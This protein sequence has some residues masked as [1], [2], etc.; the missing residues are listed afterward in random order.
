MT[1]TRAAD[2]R[3]RL[4]FFVPVANYFHAF[5]DMIQ[6]L[7][8]DRDDMVICQRIKN[9]LAISAVFHQIHLL[10][11]PQLMRNSRLRHA[12]QRGNII[13]THLEHNSTDKI[14]NLV[15]SPNTLKN[16]ARS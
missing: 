2:I 8:Q 13:H 1:G 6:T 12:Q 16:S 10:Q 9:R 3:L 15:A 4:L 5:F 14:F 7:I 11:Y